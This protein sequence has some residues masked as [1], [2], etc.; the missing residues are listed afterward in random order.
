MKRTL[1]VWWP[2]LF[3]LVLAVFLYVYLLVVPKIGTT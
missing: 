3:L 1:M 2:I